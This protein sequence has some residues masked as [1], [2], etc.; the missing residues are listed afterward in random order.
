MTYPSGEV[1]YISALVTSYVNTDGTVD[2]IQRV[3]ARLDLDRK[4]VIVPAA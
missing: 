2:N 4:P 1:H 3:S